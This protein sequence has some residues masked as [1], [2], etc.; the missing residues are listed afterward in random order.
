MA[1]L[2]GFAALG[3]EDNPELK[4]LLKALKAQ[5]IDYGRF[6]DGG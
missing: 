5:G 1:S 4:D 6:Q 3:Q 2:I